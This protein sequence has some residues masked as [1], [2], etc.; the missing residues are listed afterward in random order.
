M[1]VNLRFSTVLGAARCWGGKIK[2]NDCKT[3]DPSKRDA[4]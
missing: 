4:K 3:K 1:K 2:R